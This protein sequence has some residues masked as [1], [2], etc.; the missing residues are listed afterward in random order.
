MEIL[1]RIALLAALAVI[2]AT[3]LGSTGADAGSS[4]KSPRMASFGS[5]GE[6][7]RYA[8]S[9]AARFVGPYGLGGRTAIAETMARGAAPQQGVDFS[10]T[11]VQEEGVD[12]PDIVKTNGN[13]LFAVANGRLNAV[14]VR[15]A[16]PRLLDTLQ[17][18]QRQSH[19]LLLH[20]DRLL[21]LSRGGFWIEP[22]PGIAA[23]IAPYAP[24]QSSLAEV[25]VSD[26]GRLR[27][28][29]TLTLDGSYVAAR[30]IGGSARIV[31]GAQIPGKLPF[32][33]PQDGTKE[34]LAAATRR[35]RTVLA[36]SRVG[37]WLPSYQIKRAGVKAGQK[38]A[39]VQCRHVRKPQAFSGLGL[40]TVLT[41]DLAKGL[42]PVDSVGVMT[43]GRIVYASPE[44]LY[45]AT[46]RW[47][48]R[49]TPAKPNE[50][51]TGVTTAIHKFD[52]SS[53]VK[54]QYRGS[55]TVSGYLLSQW[56]LSEYRGVLRVVSTDSPAW[57]GTTEESESFLTTLR[58]RGGSLVQ[59]GRVGGLGKGERV[60]SVR[61]VGDVGYVVT[62]RQIDPLYTVDLALPERPRVLGEL[63]IPGY[64]AYL[65]PIGDDLLL[66]VGQDV[67]DEGRPLGTQ[68]SLFDVSN[69][70]RP[71][72]LHKASLGLGWSEAE[73]DHH[74]FLFW[75]RTGLV[76][77]PFEQRAVGFRVGR[78]RGIDPAGRIEHER[79]KLDWT[80]G[81][82]RSL[83]VRDSV[84]TV[85]ESGVKSS[86]LS[87]LTERGWAAF[88][89]PQQ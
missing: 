84:L 57:W 46:E 79:G 52:I 50:G 21:V 60:Y 56:S 64:S 19:E 45:V 82:R 71:T 43:D 17:L 42:E 85:S 78:A 9:Q 87:T 48:D 69:L 86:F 11:N 54:T 47:L 10:G 34:A 12:E 66:G 67:S 6:L 44:S 72:R 22:L 8:K 23:R 30:L 24:A 89:P 14:D 74:A 49:P 70:T 31:V 76:V 80:P 15:T 29:R 55:G 51:R 3:A 35:N 33:Q 81:V 53:P 61:F 62:F 26:P 39:L 13:T 40:L 77:I 4:A 88:P 36:A 65:H 59:A 5:C 73:S 83:V 16:A 1:K 18:D 7:L 32:V 38:R 20:G 58:D 37:S 2:A 63:K 25:D 68:L 41:V 75:P 28:V 27:L